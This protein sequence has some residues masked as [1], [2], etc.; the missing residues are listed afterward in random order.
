MNLAS[1]TL[2]H[3]YQLITLNYL[4]LNKKNSNNYIL[5]IQLSMRPSYNKQI[6]NMTNQSDF[7]DYIYFL[8]FLI[9]GD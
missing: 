4:L 3:T 1:I 7:I 6:K 8:H 9:N 5:N 2:F